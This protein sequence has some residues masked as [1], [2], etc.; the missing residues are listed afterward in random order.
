MPN[1]LDFMDFRMNRIKSFSHLIPWH[2]GVAWKLVGLTQLFPLLRERSG[3]EHLA[4]N[5]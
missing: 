1:T 3:L 4:L 5:T 2:R